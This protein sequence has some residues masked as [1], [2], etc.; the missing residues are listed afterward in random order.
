[1]KFK[2]IL[3]IDDSDIDN[4]INKSVLTKA[5]VAES[6]ITETSP[7][8][9]LNYLRELASAPDKFPDIIFLDIR[10]PEMNGFEF[11]EKCHLLPE[12]IKDRCTIYMLSSS[13][14]PKDAERAKQYSVVKKH[15]TKPLTLDQIK[16]L[17]K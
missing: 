13:I 16:I 8:A 5:N 11:L 15:I 12:N 7:V 9:A 1:M 4:F 2:Q 14:D 17:L 6:I 3:L 10:M